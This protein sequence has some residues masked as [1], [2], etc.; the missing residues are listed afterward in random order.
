MAVP[1]KGKFLPSSQCPRQWEIFGMKLKT[2]VDLKLAR[3]NET[4]EFPRF[5]QVS[6]TQARQSA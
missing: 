2:F 1:M 3:T 4:I 6:T 5:N